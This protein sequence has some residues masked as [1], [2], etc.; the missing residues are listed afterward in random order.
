MSAATAISAGPSDDYRHGLGQCEAC[1]GPLYVSGIE[2]CC[3]RCLRP[4]PEH[5][6]SVEMAADKAKADTLA[7]AN[8]GK[9]NVPV[10][11]GEFTSTVPERVAALEKQLQAALSRIAV[12]EQAASRR[13]AG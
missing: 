10:P 12:L 1:H 6:L 9:P 2:V 5:P 3:V 13:K 4:H 11:A 8:R 7:E